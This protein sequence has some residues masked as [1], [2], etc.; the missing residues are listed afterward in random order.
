MSVQLAQLVNSQGWRAA[1][2]LLHSQVRARLFASVYEDD[3]QKA[4]EMFKE[5]RMANRVAFQFQS[6]VENAAE[7]IQ[8]TPQENQ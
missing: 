4:I 5:A 6:A 8:Q 1:L 2:E 7:S 3:E